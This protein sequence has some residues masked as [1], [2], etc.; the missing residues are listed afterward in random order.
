MSQQKSLGLNVVGHVKGEYGLGQAIRSNLRAFEAVDIP[1]SIYNFDVPWHSNEDSTYSD[2]SDDY[3]YPINFVHVNPD[4]FFYQEIGNDFFKDKYNIGFWAWELTKISPYWNFAFDFFDEIWTPSNYSAEAISAV[5]PIP[6]FKLPHSIE[7]PIPSVTRE[8]LGLPKDKFIFF[9]MFD[10]HST[11]GRKNPFGLVEAFKKAFSNSNND[12]LLV[13]KHSNGSH[14]PEKLQYFLEQTENYD[15]IHLIEGHLRKEDLQGLINS[16]DCYVS[17]HRSEGFG[18]TMAEAMYYGKPVI[19]T[20]YS[21]NLEFMNMGNSYLVKYD[22]IE[23]TENDGSYPKGSVWAHPDT[24]HAAFIMRQV[25]ENQKESCKVGERAAQEMRSLLSPKNLGLK[26]KKRL[27]NVVE[28]VDNPE[29]Q[30]R[31]GRLKSN[32]DI[33]S[34]EN[35][36]QLPTFSAGISHLSGKSK[37]KRRYF[38]FQAKAWEKTAKRLLEELNQIESQAAKA[39]LFGVSI[40]TIKN[41]EFIEYCYRLILGQQPNEEEIGYWLKSI[42][43]NN[44]QPKEIVDNFLLSVK[45]K[46]YYLDE[47]ANF[48]I[49]TNSND[50]YLYY[51][52]LFLLDREPDEGGFE[53][54]KQIVENENISRKDLLSRFMK[55][56]EFF[57]KKPEIFSCLS[58]L[59]SE[60]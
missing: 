45:F 35:A 21:S 59:I 13:L 34:P 60:V 42:E 48:R 16:C 11:L 5:S 55:S 14:H 53:H 10:F 17:L 3:P 2:F 25:F 24:D 33:I 15:S 20:G 26:A 37:T 9:F 39:K 22:L 19:A 57:Q 1:F 6:V 8:D 50:K 43:N 54:W 51:S 49:E 12:V 52:Y 30:N 56:Q 27:E 31:M 4:P 38:E 36:N 29:W 23:A 41:E 32:F 7:F 18:L 28:I 58:W 40:E 47:T 44:T 46:E